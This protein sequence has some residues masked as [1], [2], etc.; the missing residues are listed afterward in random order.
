MNQK[1]QQALRGFEGLHEELI[2]GRI[3]AVEYGDPTNAGGVLSFLRIRSIATPAGRQLAV[4]ELHFGQEGSGIYFHPDDWEGLKAHLRERLE[5][6]HRP[7]RFARPARTSANAPEVMFF[8]I[9]QS[10][11]D[12]LNEKGG[13]SALDILEPLF[14]KKEARTVLF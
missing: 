10:S 12:R 14:G 6:I 4:K 8:G 3:A 1:V 7:V 11:L 9:L 2:N 5:H 13:S